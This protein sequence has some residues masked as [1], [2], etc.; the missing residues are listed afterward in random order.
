MVLIVKC[1]ESRVVQAARTAPACPEIN[2]LYPSL[3]LTHCHGVAVGTGQSKIGSLCTA[4]S[5]CQALYALLY[6]STVL[7]SLGTLPQSAV[8][9]PCLLECHITHYNV[10]IDCICRYY[11]VIGCKET[12]RHEPQVLLFI[13]QGIVHKACT[14]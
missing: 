1:L 8:H 9:T 12:I 10:R 5:L 14:A 2:D 11:I 6:H 4:V 7:R 3:D 13:A